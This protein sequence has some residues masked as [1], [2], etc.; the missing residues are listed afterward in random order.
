MRSIHALV[1]SAALVGCADGGPGNANAFSPPTRGGSTVFAGSGSDR[2]DAGDKGGGTTPAVGAPP[3]PDETQP[4]VQTTPPSPCSSNEQ[5]P[6]GRCSRVSGN[7]YCLQACETAAC[8]AGYQCVV[9]DGGSFCHPPCTTASDCPRVTG[10]TPYCAAS[11]AG[12]FCFW[13]AAEAS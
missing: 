4:P 2:G 5:C 3:V 9:A 12:R 13:S 11:D 6:G 7:G 8:G 10:L 1:I